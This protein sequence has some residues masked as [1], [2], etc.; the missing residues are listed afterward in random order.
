MEKER[1]DTPPF[2]HK[3]FIPDNLDVHLC[4]ILNSHNGNDV[5]SKLLE[6]HL[7]STGKYSPTFSGM[8]L[9]RKAQNYFISDTVSY[10]RRLESST[11]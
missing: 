8:T 4:G 10:P 2:H 7:A 11:R 5:N 3:I 1:H 9:L 6:C